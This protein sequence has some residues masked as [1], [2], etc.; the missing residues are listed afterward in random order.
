MRSSGRLF[1]M[2]WDLRSMAVID[3]YSTAEGRLLHR[4]ELVAEAGRQLK[5]FPG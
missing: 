2:R 1:A 5:K 4:D 3:R